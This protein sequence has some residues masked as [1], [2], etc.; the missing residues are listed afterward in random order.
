MMSKFYKT[1]YKNNILTA[2]KTNLWSPK[3]IISLFPP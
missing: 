3:T 1:V 2:E